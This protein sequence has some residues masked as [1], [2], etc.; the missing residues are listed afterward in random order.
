MNDLNSQINA[1]LG[2]VSINTVNAI[3]LKTLRYQQMQRYMLY[4]R[5][6]NAN[7]RATGGIGKI[8]PQL[9]LLLQHLYE[10]D[11]ETVKFNEMELEKKIFDSL[12]IVN[13]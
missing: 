6:F 9:E 3:D 7:A 1:I 10:K 11:T 5:F 2:G 12:Q 8:S 4:Q 13:H